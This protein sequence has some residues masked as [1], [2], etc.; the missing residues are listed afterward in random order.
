ML[1][2][3]ER[4]CVFSFNNVDYDNTVALFKGGFNGLG[5]TSTHFRFKCQ[6]VNDNFD[7]VPD[8]LTDTRNIINGVDFPI[9]FDP[10][11]PF[12]LQAEEGVRVGFGTFLNQR[13]K[14]VNPCSIRKFHEL[15]NNLL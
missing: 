2:E 12:A 7:I 6:S 13:R 14:H 1:T 15:V 10:C 11:V 3:E 4:G 9:N 5:Q 8:A